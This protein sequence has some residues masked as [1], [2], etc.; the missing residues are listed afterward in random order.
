MVEI[1]SVVHLKSIELVGHQVHMLNWK[2]KKK[3]GKSYFAF[4][5]DS[6][7]S[8]AVA[9]PHNRRRR[10]HHHHIDVGMRESAQIIR[11]F[12]KEACRT[13]SM[14]VRI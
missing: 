13:A 5:H 11:E 4:A 2:K 8:V 3:H 12:K 14:C 1:I 10:H 6:R 7:V 9:L